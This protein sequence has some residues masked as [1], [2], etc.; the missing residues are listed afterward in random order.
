[1]ISLTSLTSLTSLFFRQGD[2]LDDRALELQLL[3]Y[4]RWGHAILGCVVICPA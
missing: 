4:P 3:A 2:G 1:M